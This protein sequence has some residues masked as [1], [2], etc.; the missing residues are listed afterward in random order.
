MITPVY[1]LEQGNAPL[2]ISMPHCGE[3]LPPALAE[4]MTPV[5]RC[6]PDTDWHIPLLYDFVRELGAS[7]LRPTYSRYVVDLNRSCDGVNLY[8]GQ[9]TTTLCPTFTFHE[10]SIYADPADEP[11][12]AEIASRVEQYWRPYHDA[13]RAEI[14]RLVAEHG[15]VLVWEAHSI[16]SELPMLFEGKLPN[17]NLGS[18]A[19]LACA[20]EVLAAAAAVARES[21]YTWS[22]D[23]RFKGGYITRH[24]GDPAH[25]VHLL[26]LEMGRCAYMDES[27]PWAYRE[28]VAARVRVPLRAMVEGALAALP[29]RR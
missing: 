28:A 29:A 24:F 17:L 4:R 13:L 9:K 5:A 8:P 14:D 3:Q 26:Q 22:A 25:G 11:D 18:N 10:E 16:E 12:D 2:L 23:G 15:R 21:G 19:G 7:I 20:P 6:V 27:A 1:T